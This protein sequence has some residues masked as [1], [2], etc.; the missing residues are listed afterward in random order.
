MRARLVDSAALVHALAGAGVLRSDEKMA[1]HTTLHLGGPVEAWV[2]P[3][4]S[5]AASRVLALCGAKAW[6]CHVLGAGSNV[7]VSDG[8]LAGVVLSSQRLSWIE[9]GLEGQD[10][11]YV[12]VGAGVT[13]QKLLAWAI[14]EGLGGLEFLAGIP[15]SV[16]GGL[17][18]NAGTLLG[19]F[20]DVTRSVVSLTA[21]G[22][23]I[24]RP[25]SACG[26]VYRGS[27]L[28]PR[29]M[30]VEGELR[31]VPRTAATILAEVRSLY[32]RRRRREPRQVFSAGSIFKNP[33][34]DYAGRLI[35]ACGM[36]GMRHGG[37]AISSVHANWI[38]HEGGATAREFLA[39]I[40]KV[41]Q[42]VGERFGITLELEIKVLGEAN[43]I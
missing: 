27:V 29:E 17:A 30:I 13:T 18:M 23:S 34:G 19:A 7:L 28:P 26:F 33:P 32:A 20:K 1:L 39:L 40:A 25:A 3:A 9:R 24:T 37:A 38:V 31:L 12:R 43:E 6:P 14:R 8:G 5:E 36:K 35:E 41:R 4:T 10:G 22:K 42:A 11:V 21:E 15:G 16:G 2:E